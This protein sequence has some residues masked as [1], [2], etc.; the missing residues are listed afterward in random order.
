VDLLQK[1]NKLP[2]TGFTEIPKLTARDRRLRPGF[3]YFKGIAKY[4]TVRFIGIYFLVILKF[5]F[6]SMSEIFLG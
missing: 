3:Y 4:F 5:Y 2:S 1:P 6:V